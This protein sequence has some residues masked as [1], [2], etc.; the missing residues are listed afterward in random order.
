VLGLP[1]NFDQPMPYRNLDNEQDPI[2]VP[3][4]LAPPRTPVPA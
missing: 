2:P 3:T 4:T 1:Y